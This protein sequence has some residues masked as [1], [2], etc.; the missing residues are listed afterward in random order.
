[1]TAPEARG[2]IAAMPA[3]E[4]PSHL[5]LLFS[6]EV[7]CLREESWDRVIRASS[8]R[9]GTATLDGLLA[10][11][12]FSNAMDTVEWPGPGAMPTQA[13]ALALVADC[14]DSGPRTSAIA[15]GFEP[16]VRVARWERCAAEIATDCGIGGFASAALR[17]LIED[18]EENQKLLAEYEAKDG[19]SGLVLERQGQSLVLSSSGYG[20]GAYDAWWGMSEAGRPVCLAIDFDVLAEGVFTEGR[21]PLPLKRGTTEIPGLPSVRIAA[22]LFGRERPAVVAKGLAP[23]HYVYTRVVDAEGKLHAPKVEHGAKG[24]LK[25]DLRPFSSATT[26]VVRLVTGSRPMAIVRG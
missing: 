14:G 12:P 25:L 1:V 26:L 11:D 19:W 7:V 4:F 16:Q 8:K 15:L 2:T 23:L 17:K 10:G 24:T 6:A 21:V 3:S 22:G 20:D 13:E 5:D 9:L 18:E